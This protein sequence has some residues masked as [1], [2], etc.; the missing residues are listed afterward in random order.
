MDRHPRRP[1]AESDTPS[2][3]YPAT[4]MRRLRASATLR[5][6]VQETHLRAD[7]L[8][9][10]LFLTEAPAGREPIPSLPGIDRL[11]LDAALHDVE[12]HLG[13]GVR[14]FLLFAKVPDERK[15]NAGAYALDHDGFCARA[16]RAI[17]SRFPES[18]VMTDVALD[19]YSVYGHD[20]I[21]ED[22]RIVNDPSVAALARMALVHAEAG[23][24]VVA[25]SDMMDGRVGAIRATLEA[26]GHH[27][28]AILAYGAKY[29]SSYFGPFRDALDSAPGF[30]D[31]KTYQMNPANVREALREVELDVAEGADIVMVKPALAYLD[32]IARVR[33]AFDVPLAAYQVSGEYAQIMAAA[34]RGWL[35][36]R[37]GALEALTAI[38]RAGA[39]IIVTYF[40]LAAAGWLREGA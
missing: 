16:I 37:A 39:D 8:V 2:P 6:L 7:Q 40:A 36:A 26:H 10:P 17:K 14:S 23:A 30:G 27:D 34:E 35:D 22:G 12:R 29:A 32:V 19:P 5:A 3:G 21:V 25:P 28:V 18:C 20:G 24:D 11:S 38:R 15:D 1:P 31:K 33:D 13:A 9:A 4:R